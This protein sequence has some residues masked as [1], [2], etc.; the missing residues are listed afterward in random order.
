LLWD[1][2]GS[3][4]SYRA[5]LRAQPK[6]ARGHQWYAGLALQFG[7]FDQ[8][9]DEARKGLELDPFD[10][11]GQNTYGYYLWHA[12]RLREAASHLESLLT[13]TDLLYAH[14]NLGQIYAGLAAAS[15]E[16]EATDFYVK[17]MREAGIVRARELEAS[18]QS[19]SAGYLKWSDTI[20]AQAH[21]ARGDRASARI[22]ADRLEHGLKAGKISAAAVAWAQS[23]IGNYPRAIELLE[24]GAER[25]ERE[26]LYV[27]V[28]PLF[29]PL[30]GDVRFRA[31]LRRM[32][33]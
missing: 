20:F 14:I 30:H 12:G 28:M 22:Y 32:G 9:L 21:A 17:S 13:K 19:D 7:R 33:L 1:W 26:M 5:A 29:R 4:E 10:Y 11:P 27:R 3:E 25:R 15:A 24:L 16:P 8:A 23:A 18:G 6:F 31:V 2:T